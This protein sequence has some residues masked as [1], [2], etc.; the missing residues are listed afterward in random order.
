[1]TDR[2]AS[3]GWLATTAREFQTR[4]LPWI[5]ITLLVAAVFSIVALDQLISL[6]FEAWR[7]YPDRPPQDSTL[8]FWHQ[9]VT[10]WLRPL[11]AA[12]FVVGGAVGGFHLV[13]GRRLPL[14]ILV[15]GLLT[16]FLVVEATQGVGQE[17]S[18]LT[19]IERAS[20]V[21]LALVVLLIAVPATSLAVAVW[22][23]VRRDHESSHKPLPPL[24][25][26]AS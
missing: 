6:H 7:V 24:G 11:L 3:S 17:V 26:A 20:S 4:D 1:M 21:S 19:E 25:R 5:L 14:A 12:L 10:G 23:V 13:N 15:G 16:H 8:A 22:S 2:T 18:P 9:M